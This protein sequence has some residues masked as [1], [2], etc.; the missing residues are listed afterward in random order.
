MRDHKVIRGPKN[1]ATLA[2]KIQPGVLSCM[3]G[4]YAVVCSLYNYKVNIQEEK[5]QL[6]PDSCQKRVV[7]V[8]TSQ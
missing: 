2:K 5:R 3:F 7:A 6:Q 4:R 8:H 1:I